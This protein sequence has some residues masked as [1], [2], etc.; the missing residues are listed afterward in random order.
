MQYLASEMQYTT[1]GPAD[2]LRYHFGDGRTSMLQH[3]YL[4]FSVVG[5]ISHR[6]VLRQRRCGLQYH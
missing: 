6:L 1:V 3:M 4:H 5:T 2:A